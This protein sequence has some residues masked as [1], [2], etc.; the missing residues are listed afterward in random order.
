MTTLFSG[1]RSLLS[2]FVLKRWDSAV[3]DALRISRAHGRN[4]E[5]SGLARQQDALHSPDTR[6]FQLLKFM[7][8]RI[9]IQAIYRREH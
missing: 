2:V 9:P 6:S 5:L 1:D 3:D 7:T 8:D 4:L